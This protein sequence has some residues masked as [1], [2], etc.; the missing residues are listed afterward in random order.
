MRTTGTPDATESKG[1][2][3]HQAAPIKERDPCT[4]QLGR[5]FAQLKDMGQHLQLTALSCSAKHGIY[6]ELKWIDL[7]LFCRDVSHQDW[8]A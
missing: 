1:W 6:T 3:W 8:F 5:G 7:R 2:Q 4:F